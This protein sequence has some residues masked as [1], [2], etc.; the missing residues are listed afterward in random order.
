MNRVGRDLSVKPRTIVQTT[1]DEFGKSSDL[2]KKASTWYLRSDETIAVL[3]LQRSLYGPLYYLNVA[4]WLLALEP[5]DT[6]SEF[7]CH[8]RTRASRLVPAEL[9]ERLSELLDLGRA[10]DDETRRAELLALLHMHVLPVM[11]ASA[12]LDGLRTGSGLHL[13][14]HALVNHDAQQLLVG[15]V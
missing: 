2:R 3:N 11:R 13:V 14:D 4:V 10:I 9:E 7:K 12:T 1:L 5:V 15:E 6:P 8:I